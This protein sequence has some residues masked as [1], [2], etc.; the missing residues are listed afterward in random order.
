[1][2]PSSAAHKYEKRR[3]NPESSLMNFFWWKAFAILQ[4]ILLER[5]NCVTN[6]L[7]FWKIES[8]KKIKIKKN[9]Q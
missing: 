8:P 6:S 1:M 9:C 4:K 3:K 2:I 7:L 5:N